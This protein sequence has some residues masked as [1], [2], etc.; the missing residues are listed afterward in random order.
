[1]GSNIQNGD[2]ANLGADSSLPWSYSTKTAPNFECEW[3]LISKMEMGLIWEQ[4]HPFH[5]AILLKLLLILS[6]NGV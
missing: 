4:T 3:G 6:V 5:G 1:M 2:G